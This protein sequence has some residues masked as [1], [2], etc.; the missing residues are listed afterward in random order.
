MIK[1]IPKWF[2]NLFPVGWDENEWEMSRAFA[3]E[4]TQAEQIEWD[5]AYAAW[6]KRK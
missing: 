4:R 2:R 6:E 1:R 3:P 5:K